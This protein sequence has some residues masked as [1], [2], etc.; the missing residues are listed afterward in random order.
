MADSVG[1]AG[2]AVGIVSLCLQIY[3][4]IY[5]Y[6][7]DFQYRDQYV[8]DVPIRLDRLRSLSTVVKSAIPAL[9]NEHH[10]PSQEVI[11][12]L[13]DCEASMQTLRTELQNFEGRT[14]ATDL[15]GKLK[16]TKR[17]IQ[18]PFARPDLEKL[19]SNLDRM[20]N[21]LMVALQGLGLHVQSASQSKLAEISNSTRL[22]IAEIATV[23]TNVDKIQSTELALETGIKKNQTSLVNISQDLSALSLVATEV[24]SSASR[25]RHIQD[26]VSSNKDDLH[27]IAEAFK[28]Q[29]LHGQR[30]EE[31]ITELKHAI[32]SANENSPAQVLFQ[33]LMSK[34]DVLRRWQ[35]E[36]TSVQRA[37]SN[38]RVD[39]QLEPNIFQTERQLSDRNR[40]CGCRRRRRISRRS[41]RWLAFTWF[42]ESAVESHH[43]PGCPRFRATMAK[44][45]SSAGIVFTGLHRFLNTAI[46]VS[47]T[48]RNGAGGAAISPTFRYY[49][50]VDESRSPA[51]RII[52]CM[53]SNISYA[54][55]GVYESK[56][57]DRNMACDQIIRLGVS[58]LQRIFASRTSLPTD[59]NQYGC[60][61][62]DHSVNMVSN[63]LPEIKRSVNKTAVCQLEVMM[64]NLG[65]HWPENYCLSANGLDLGNPIVRTWLAEIDALRE[66]HAAYKIIRKLEARGIYPFKELGLHP[67]DYRL[68]RRFHSKPGSIYHDLRNIDGLNMAF[69]MGFRDIDEFYCGFTPIMNYNC[70]PKVYEWFFDHGASVTNLIPCSCNS[71]FVG[72]AA[73]AH[74]PAWTVAH[75]IMDRI[76]HRIHDLTINRLILRLGS[77]DL[78]DGCNCGCSGFE[79]G[80]NPLVVFLHGSRYLREDCWNKTRVL[81]RFLSWFSQVATIFEPA[82]LPTA[83]AIIRVCTFEALEIR[84]TCCIRKDELVSWE[85]TSEDFSHIRDEDSFLLEELEE[86]MAEFKE[87]FQPREQAL[88]Q[89]ME[90][91]WMERMERVGQEKAAGRLTK[92]EKDS[93]MRLGVVLTSEETPEGIAAEDISEEKRRKITI[94]NIVEDCCFEMNDIWA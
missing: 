82:T 9:Q 28:L 58:K 25:I 44:H 12:C 40:A 41:S 20:S 45:E 73:H 63:F 57:V 90:S 27:D 33:M 49:A 76:S 48:M 55:L 18:F 16:E 84:H 31:S 91:Y 1:V 24:Q 70:S 65:P 83:H 8:K 10:A 34:P 68:S 87:F 67:H 59:V 64:I 35:D 37:S 74:I 54:I 71:G 2:T 88:S 79:G 19:A 61:L 62:I 15:K 56:M 4:G 38:I 51:F 50:M 81:S 29:Q 11:Q 13:Q 23:K 30:L 46:A 3:D 93:A 66:N 72:D 32:V 14:S 6:L 92:E 47:L 7:K 43:E 26:G 89:F 69:E 86:L 85:E 80:C 52:N 17:K 22:A 39:D 53:E 60:S 21:W 42:N 94:G 75:H 77:M 36:A 78:G 5:S